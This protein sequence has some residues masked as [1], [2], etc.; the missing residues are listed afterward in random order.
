MHAGTTIEALRQE[1]SGLTA[2]RERARRAA[3]DGLA[4]VAE[5][6]SELVKMQQVLR[7]CLCTHRMFLLLS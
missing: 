1:I 7:G 2:E 6:E 5:L 4:R 3:A